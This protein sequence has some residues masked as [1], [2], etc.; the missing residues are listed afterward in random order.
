MFSASTFLQLVDDKKGLLA[1]RV[2]QLQYKYSRVYQLVFNL[3]SNGGEASGGRN[4]S[5]KAARTETRRNDSAVFDV[6]FV[7]FLLS[8]LSGCNINRVSVDHSSFGS[9]RWHSSQ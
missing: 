7:L 3:T 1:A 8:L 2:Y 9:Y 4:S 6:R 5:H